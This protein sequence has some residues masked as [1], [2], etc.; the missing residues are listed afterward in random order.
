[1]VGISFSILMNIHPLLAKL[2][3]LF[4]FNLGGGVG[5]GERGSG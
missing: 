4:C 3:V 5:G 2:K 1:M